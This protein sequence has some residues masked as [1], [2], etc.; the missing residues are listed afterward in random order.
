[1]APGTEDEPIISSVPRDES[2]NRETLAPASS[3][4]APL[5]QPTTFIFF[6]DRDLWS[7]SS[8]LN[9]CQIVRE[10]EAIS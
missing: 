9:Y 7:H 8:A 5:R 3:R 4:F 6:S 10:I 2:L 1:L